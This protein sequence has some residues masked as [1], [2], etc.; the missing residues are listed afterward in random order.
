MTKPKRRYRITRTHEIFDQQMPS[1]DGKPLC[2][3]SNRLDALIVCNALTA[4]PP[5]AEL[6]NAVI[7]AIDRLTRCKAPVLVK[8]KL[9]TKNDD[10]V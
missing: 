1:A 6:V 8:K 3:C 5:A 7:R 4:Q 2:T 10:T 9:R